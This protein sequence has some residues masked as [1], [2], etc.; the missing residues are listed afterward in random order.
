MNFWCKA[1][2]FNHFVEPRGS[3]RKG[4]GRLCGRFPEGFRK[5]VEGFWKIVWK[6]SGRVPEDCGRFPEGLVE[7]LCLDGF[8]MVLSDLSCRCIAIGWSSMLDRELDR[9][10]NRISDREPDR[11]QFPIG[12]YI[13]HYKMRLRLCLGVGTGI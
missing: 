6:V 2:E 13:A 8:G 7:G 9:E 3:V 12:K 10:T 5:I 4:S 1:I 11:E